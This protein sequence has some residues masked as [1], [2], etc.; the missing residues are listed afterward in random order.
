[1]SNARGAVVG[2]L[3]ASLRRVEGERI[4]PGRLL[5]E[6]RLPEVDEELWTEDS[7]EDHAGWFCVRTDPFPCPAAGC[8]FVAG[9]MTPAPPL[10]LW[11]PNDDPHPPWHPPPG[12]EGRRQPP[13][14]AHTQPHRPRA[15]DH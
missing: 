8:L 5:L 7:G 15:P 9:V 14:G 4:E 12:E 1:M 3:L 2:S 6:E 11:G 10:P 13:S